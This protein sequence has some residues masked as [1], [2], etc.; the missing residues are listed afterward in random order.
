MN[1]TCLGI[2]EML[3]NKAEVVFFTRQIDVELVLVGIDL[4][5][6]LTDNLSFA[7]NLSAS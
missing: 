1:T 2:I 7:Q 4:N 5:D 3:I 6:I